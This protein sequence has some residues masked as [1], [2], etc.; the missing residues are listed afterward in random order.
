[1]L[2]IFG[3]DIPI[4]RYVEPQIQTQS[5]RVEGEVA[6]KMRAIDV[7]AIAEDA[8]RRVVHTSPN[9][10]QH[11]ASHDTAKRGIRRLAHDKPTCWKAQSNSVGPVETD[12]VRDCTCG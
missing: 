1:M 5:C 11:L 7:R 6:A 2:R 8:W 3:R 10:R 4:A 12:F 9:R